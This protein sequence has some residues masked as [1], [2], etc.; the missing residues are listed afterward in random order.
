MATADRHAAEALRLWP[1]E[2]Q[3]ADLVHLLV[4]AAR[5]KAFG[6]FPGGAELTDRGLALAE[7]LGD[8]GLLTGSG[9]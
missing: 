9:T 6:G 7:Q 8:A 3:D 4:E 2:R 1:P 5:I